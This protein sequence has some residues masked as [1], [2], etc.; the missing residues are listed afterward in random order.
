MKALRAFPYRVQDPHLGAGAGH[1][2]WPKRDSQGRRH[3]SHKALPS[4]TRL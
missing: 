3:V 4:K 1:P 2:G